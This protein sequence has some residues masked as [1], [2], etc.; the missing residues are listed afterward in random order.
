MLEMARRQPHGGEIDWVMA[1][2]EDFRSDKRFDLIIMTGHAFQVLE[3]D[4]AIAATLA[5]MR[6]HLTPGGRV[7]FESRNPAIDWVRQWNDRASDFEHGGRLIRRSTEVVERAGEFVTFHQHFA[8]PD[9]TLTSTSRL[10]FA[11]QATIERLIGAAGLRVEALYGDW[12][13]GPFD[14]AVSEEMVFV[15]GAT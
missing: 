4:S 13:E 1:G 11:P 5:T 9:R 15:L 8:L 14:P 2:A 12:H 7:V 10:R 3:T 6:T